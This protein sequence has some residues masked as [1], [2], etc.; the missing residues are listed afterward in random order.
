MIFQYFYCGELAD[1]CP[2]GPALP[3]CSVW[4][5]WRDAADAAAAVS[6]SLCAHAC[7]IFTPT[8]PLPHD[9]WKK[10]SALY[11]AAQGQHEPHRK[12]ILCPSNERGQKK[13]MWTF[14]NFINFIF[15]SRH[16][17]KLSKGDNSTTSQKINTQKNNWKLYIQNINRTPLIFFYRI[18]IYIYIRLSG[19]KPDADSL[20]RKI[21]VH[22]FT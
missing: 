9:K 16:I 12:C 5:S 3:V 22:I 7:S 10:R 14:F 21:L 6:A 13:G 19:Y 11:Q 4:L 2:Q 1:N 8:A 20:K 18:I 15:L 17:Y